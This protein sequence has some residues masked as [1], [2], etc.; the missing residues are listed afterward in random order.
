MITRFAPS[1]TGYL[2]LGHAVAAHYAFDFAAQRGGTCLLRIEDIDHTR[3]RPHF[4]DAIYEDL[5]WLG[6]AWP[7]PVRVQSAHLSDYAA[8]IEAL[9]ERGLAY[10]CFKSRAELPRGVYH[11]PETPLPDHAQAAKIMAGEPFAW[12]LSMAV[13]R[14]TLGGDFIVNYNDGGREVTV[15]PSHYGDVVLARK[16][17][18]SSYLIAVT[19]DDAAQGITD[20]VRGADFV[21]QTG[22]HVLIQ[23]LMGWPT[24]RYHHHP[25]LMGTNGKKLSKRSGSTAIRRLRE[26]GETPEAVMARALKALEANSPIG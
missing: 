23:R 13:A 4:T 9:C 8:V 15:D 26:S 5:R 24:P 2:H 12:R 21:D 20:I 3:C 25:L 6:F 10:R 22:L 1:P 17:I 14:E 7:T 11:G 18:G 16:D 19:R